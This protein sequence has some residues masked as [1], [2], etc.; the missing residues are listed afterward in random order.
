[1]CLGI[2]L[3]CSSFVFILALIVI[4]LVTLP[5]LTY[6]SGFLSPTHFHDSSAGPSTFLF[7]DIHKLLHTQLILGGL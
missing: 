1:M 3:F 6:T 2:S 7:S 4:E 5:L